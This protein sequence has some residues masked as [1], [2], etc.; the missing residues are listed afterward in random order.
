MHHLNIC[1]PNLRNEVLGLELVRPCRTTGLADG[2]AIPLTY[3][4]LKYDIRC[5]KYVVLTFG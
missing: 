3:E 1:I 5:G 2:C 4:Y